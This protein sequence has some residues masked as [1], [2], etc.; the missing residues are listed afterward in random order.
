MGFFAQGPYDGG[1][2][3]VE[4]YD[5]C[6][7]DGGDEQTPPPTPKKEPLEFKEIGGGDVLLTEAIVAEPPDGGNGGLCG[8]GGRGGGSRATAP[9]F[10]MQI[11]VPLG[12]GEATA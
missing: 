3:E 11:V 12:T 4:E 10:K 5:S 1:T 9:Q 7:G 8:C 2:D 6:E